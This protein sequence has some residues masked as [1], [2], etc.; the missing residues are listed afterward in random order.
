MKC[1]AAVGERSQALRVYR[2]FAD[3]MREELEAEPDGETTSFFER[4]QAG[5][6]TY[7]TKQFGAAA[8]L[9]IPLSS[10]S[11][12]SHVTSALRENG[13]RAQYIRGDER[14]ELLRGDHR[15]TGEGEFVDGPTQHVQPVDLRTGALP[16]TASGATTQVVLDEASLADLGIRPGHAVGTAVDIGE[17]GSS[18]Q[19]DERRQPVLPGVVVGVHATEPDG[20]V[21]TIL[22]GRSHGP[23][24]VS[25]VARVNPADTELVHAT[26]ATVVPDVAVERI[27][28]QA[29]LA[30]VIEQQQRAGLALSL[31][32]LLIGGLGLLTTRLAV[33]RER[34]VEL[35]IRRSLGATRGAIVTSVLT[36]TLLITA[37]AS[38]AA[39]VLASIVFPLIPSGFLTHGAGT[40]SQLTL[41][42]ISIVR[43]VIGASV[44]GLVAALVPAV[45]A[46]R[47]SVVEAVRR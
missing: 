18:A 28:K 26:A 39:V 31:L 35:G 12:A 23:A 24:S 25:V 17:L 19:F 42:L 36:E 47:T 21:R 5:A 20:V 45:Q 37:V 10:L 16:T 44:I 27:D 4:L 40:V 30:P 32:A 13:V 11:Q 43:G 41:P 3:R 22:I 7:L 8:T 38:G 15:S 33:V 46:G 29:Q 9:Q 2:R 6:T 1:H 14:V 34:R